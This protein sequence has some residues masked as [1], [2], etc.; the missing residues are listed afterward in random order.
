LFVK[1]LLRHLDDEEDFAGTP[2]KRAVFLFRR[3]KI[4]YLLKDFQ[5]ESHL[6]IVVDEYGGTS[7]LVS[8]MS[9]KK[10]LG[11]LVMSLMMTMSILLK[12]T[13]KTIYLRVK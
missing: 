10:L 11:I 12:S 4:R 3:I 2:F 8:K 6:A 1:D 9:L 7:G 5:N 13:K